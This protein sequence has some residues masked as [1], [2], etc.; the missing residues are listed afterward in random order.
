MNRIIPLSIF[1]CLM[2]S[3]AHSQNTIII[4]NDS[5]KIKT[6]LI[7]TSEA[8]DFIESAHPLPASVPLEVRE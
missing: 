1:L 5:V 2:I 6:D 4:L 7:S 3:Y 8:P